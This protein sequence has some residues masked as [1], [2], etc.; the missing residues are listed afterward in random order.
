M[1]KYE[2]IYKYIWSINDILLILVSKT[3]FFIFVSMKMQ[4]YTE[5]SYFYNLTKII[6]QNVRNDRWNRCSIS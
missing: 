2:M 4:N 3:V 5:N 6:Y 1:E